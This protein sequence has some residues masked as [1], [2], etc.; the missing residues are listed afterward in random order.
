M[1]CGA[2]RFYVAVVL[3]KYKVFRRKYGLTAYIVGIHALPA[4]RQCATV[5][6]YVNAVVG[7]IAQYVFVQAHCLLLIAAEEV[8]LDCFD[9]YVLEPFHLLLSYYRTVHKS[10]GSLY[11]VVPMA[12]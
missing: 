9:A 7:R 1:E 10:G 6:Y 2:E 5:K 12:A 4:S 11:Y 3:V 8:N